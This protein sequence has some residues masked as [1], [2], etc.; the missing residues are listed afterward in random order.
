MVRFWLDPSVEFTATVEGDELLKVTVL[1]TDI[2]PAAPSVYS[3][4]FQ[5][6]VLD[7]ATCDATGCRSSLPG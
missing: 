2:D 1:F 3:P 5:V 7:W 6:D 4:G